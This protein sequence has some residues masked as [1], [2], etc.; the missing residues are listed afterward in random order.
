M[1]LKLIKDNNGRTSEER[2][3]LRELQNEINED[4][5]ANCEDP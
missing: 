1:S 3:A 4:A 5:K 2:A